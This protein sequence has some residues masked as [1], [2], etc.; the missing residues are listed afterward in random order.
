MVYEGTWQYAVAAG[1]GLSWWWIFAATTACVLSGVAKITRKETDEFFRI[2]AAGALSVA[3]GRALIYHTDFLLFWT[4]P[5]VQ[6]LGTVGLSAIFGF[7][8]AKE[9]RVQREP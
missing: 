3:V 9:R 1:L 6:I 4:L 5:A 2:F 8:D 7:I